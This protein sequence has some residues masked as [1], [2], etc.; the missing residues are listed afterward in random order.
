[1]IRTNSLDVW[2]L[3]TSFLAIYL[4]TGV[5]VPYVNESGVLKAM[6]ISLMDIM[7]WAVA[8][9]RLVLVDGI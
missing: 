8:D 2:V 7:V 4:L 1:V 3:E 5:V 9:C 6:K